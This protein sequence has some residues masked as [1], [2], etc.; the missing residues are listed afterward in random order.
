MGLLCLLKGFT[1]KGG[2]TIVG[3]GSPWH[4]QLI[5]INGNVS[6]GHSK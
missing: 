5:G 1:Q 3:G 6:L 2:N 4:N